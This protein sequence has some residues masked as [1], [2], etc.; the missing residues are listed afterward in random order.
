MNQL[1]HQIPATPMKLTNWKYLPGTSSHAKK[2][3]N[4]MSDSKLIMLEGISSVLII[5]PIKLWKQSIWLGR[6]KGTQR[7]TG[8]A[9]AW[10]FS[11]SHQLCVFVLLLCQAMPLV[12]LPHPLSHLPSPYL[13]LSLSLSVPH[14]LHCLSRNEILMEDLDLSAAYHTAVPYWVHTVYYKSRAQARATS[15]HP[16]ST[17]INAKAF[18]GNG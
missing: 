3:D 7:E 10:R 4:L 9:V 17:K 6:G 12:S 16:T 15:I 5:N 1:G 14:P 2:N 18:H 8:S 13:S 11:I